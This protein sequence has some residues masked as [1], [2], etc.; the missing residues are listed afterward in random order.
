MTNVEFYEYGDVRKIE[1]NGHAGYAECGSDIVCAGVSALSQAYVFYMQ[2]LVDKG[3]AKIDSLTIINGFLE[4]YSENSSPE[5]KAAYDLIKQGI[6]A[7]SEA[8]PDNVKI[9]SKKMK[10]NQNFG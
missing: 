3:E 6:E 4:I 8:F 9:F 7:I 1:I 2:D 10:K 5:S